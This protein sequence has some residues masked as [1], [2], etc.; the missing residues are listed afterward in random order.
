MRTVRAKRRRIG[1]TLVEL[2]VVIAV[3][4]LLVSILVPVI[5]VVLDAAETARS[6]ARIFDLSNGCYLYKDAKA[7]FPG[8]VKHSELVGG[9]SGNDLTGS[10]LL[11][12]EL[13]GGSYATIGDT[14][15]DPPMEGDWASVKTKDIDK[16]KPV[17]NGPWKAR[18]SP[19]IGS[20][21]DQFS[22]SLAVLYYP[23][24]KHL[25]S[26]ASA[27]D[28]YPYSDNSVYVNST[29]LYEEYKFANEKDSSYTE[30]EYKAEMAE[31]F[32]DIREITTEDNG[33]TTTIGVRNPGAFILI[34]AGKDRLYL[35]NDDIRYP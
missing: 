31:A 30:A 25:P 10:Q 29:D 15:T 1:L 6:R 13:F 9:S 32:E 12:V 33:S 22:D 18:Y 8:Q 28:L 11:A 34:G 2:L 17:A 21:L 19:K 4:G 26:T 23:C 24:R 16:F 27:D 14:L 3:I 35:T 5:K 7:F 20:V